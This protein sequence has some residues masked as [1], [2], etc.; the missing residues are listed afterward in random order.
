MADANP[1]PSFLSSMWSGVKGFVKGMFAGGAV[2]AVAGAVIGAVIGVA[3]GGFS[4]VALGVMGVTAYFGALAMGSIGGMAGMA[5]EVVRSR[6][7]VQP[8][9]NDIIN[10]AKV[11]YAQG[12]ATGHGM[13]Q[14]QEA[15]QTTFRD[16][17]LQRRSAAQVQTPAVH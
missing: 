13:A 7:A 14:Q 15:E 12:I 11:S 6:E 8:S 5:T 4:A 16:K 17:E 3:T 9:A 2:G 1:R 10:V